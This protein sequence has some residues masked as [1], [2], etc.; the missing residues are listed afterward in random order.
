ML[1]TFIFLLLWIINKNTVASTNLCEYKCHAHELAYMYDN[2]NE[3][4]RRSIENIESIECA[5]TI[6]CP[7]QGNVIDFPLDFSA[8]DCETD[9]N[10]DKT[11]IPKEDLL[12]LR[13]ESNG[14]FGSLSA[15][16][17]S[18]LTITA[19]YED[20]YGK[21]EDHYRSIWGKVG[22]NTSIIPNLNRAD[23]GY[24]Q[25]GFDELK[26]F[27]TAG[28]VVDGK[29]AYSLGGP[30]Q[31]VGIYQERY[32]DLDANG[33][34]KGKDETIKTMSIGVEFAF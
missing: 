5:E 28:A 24:Y 23:I 17:F 11:A 32:V 3:C 1:K 14:W 4:S 20:M 29:L 9:V 15:D 22:F 8:N 6:T 21:D 34:I 33:K 7:N 25:T 13:T 2:C 16:I 19:A 26:E 10:G 30:A 18:I 27:K 31:L 12:D